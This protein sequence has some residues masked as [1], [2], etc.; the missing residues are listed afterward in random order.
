MREKVIK[1]VSD[2]W[3]NTFEVEN[4]CETNQYNLNLEKNLDIIIN[5]N[6]FI[7]YGTL[8]MQVRFA[9]IRLYFL[10]YYDF[11]STSIHGN[12]FFVKLQFYLNRF[13]SFQTSQLPKRLCNFHSLSIRSLISLVESPSHYSNSKLEYKLF[14]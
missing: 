10:K 12:S 5:Y 4:H 6:I 7:R 13:Q 14:Y 1:Q 9:H 11:F 2:F 8:G 3:I